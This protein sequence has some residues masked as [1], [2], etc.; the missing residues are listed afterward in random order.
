M[1]HTKRS[2][3]AGYCAVGLSVGDVHGYVQ[4]AGAPPCFPGRRTPSAGFS[5]CPAGRQGFERGRC[6]RL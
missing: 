5:A 6:G 1:N 3:L 2:D 4:A